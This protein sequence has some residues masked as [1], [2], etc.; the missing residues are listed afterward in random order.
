MASLNAVAS[1]ACDLPF[2]VP[3]SRWDPGVLL[4]GIALDTDRR[5]RHG[6]FVEAAQLFDHGHFNVSNAE[7]AATDPQQSLVLEHGYATLH[8]TGVNRSVL[9]GS[10]AGVAVG[11]YATEFVQILAQSP[12]RRSV[13]AS[14]NALSVACGRVSFALGLH[15]PCA[16][17]ETACSASLVAIPSAAAAAQCVSRST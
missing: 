2:E 7:A 3:A 12:L 6:A 5:A 13:Y 16:S 10:G 14:T 11:I 17:F 8:A 1:A 15:G 9:L 4:A